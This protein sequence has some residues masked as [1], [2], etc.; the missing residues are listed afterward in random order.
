MIDV[1]L[2]TPELIRNLQRKLYCK[3]KTEPNFRFYQLYDKIWRADILAHAYAL[4]RANRGAP[5][6]DGMTFEQIESQGTES[7]LSSLQEELKEK[8]YRP[9]PVR[10]V[11]IPKA[12]GGERPLGLPTIKDRVIQTA[13]K[14]VLEPI[15]EADMEDCAYGYRPKRSAVD[16]VKVVHKALTE[17]YTQVVDADLSKYFDRIPHD[18]LMRSI[19]LRIVDRAVLSLLKSWLQVPVQGDGPQGPNSLSGGKGNKLGT[20]QG[21]VISPLLANRYMNRF[22]RYWHQCAGE[23]QFAAKL[24][25]YADDFVILSR[26]KAQH[27]LAWTR[28]AMTRLKLE[29]NTSKTSVRN[30]RVESFDFLGYRFG[31]M[32]TFKGHSQGYLGARASDKSIQKLK[33]RVG[34]L[35]RPQSGAWP[36]IRDRLNRTL[37]G[38]KNYFHYGSVRKSYTAVNQH[39]CTKVRNFLQRRHKVSSRGTRQFDDRAIFDSYGVFELTSR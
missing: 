3:A 23:K 34:E 24:V 35:L 10:R 13:A 2:T 21:G 16:A 27:A 12:G 14:L 19:A 7:W 15:F 33:D 5:G 20:P 17:G 32:Y 9:E 31:L 37:S 1:S 22:L 38:W 30:A 18:D 36:E 11:M 25:N 4:S 28:Q 39:V 8:R 26:G 29:I 6:V